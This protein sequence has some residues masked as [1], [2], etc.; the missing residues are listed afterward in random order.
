LG[1]SGA[2]TAAKALQPH[3]L[4]EFAG[5]DTRT[6]DVENRASPARSSGATAEIA[7]FVVTVRSATR[8]CGGASLAR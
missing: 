5:Q 2:T 6:V 4:R 3:G 7:G 8:A 1:N